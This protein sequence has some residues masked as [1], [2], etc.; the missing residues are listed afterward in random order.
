MHDRRSPRILDRVNEQEI[1]RSGVTVPARVD[2]RGVRGPTARQA[3]GQRWRRT[4]PGLYVPS[5]IDGNA[6]EQRIVEAAAGLPDGTAV[7]GWAALA[8][9][10]TPWF[11]GLAPDGRT[12]LPVPVALDDDRML[13]RRPGVRLSNDWLFDDDV[14]WVDGVPITVPERSV[15]FA[16]RRARSLVHAVQIIDMAAAGDRVDLDE[17]QAYLTRLPS[18]PGI[19]RLRLAVALGDENAWS[20][21]EPPMRMIWTA[22]GHPRPRCNLPLFGPDGQ[23]LLT[24]DLFDPE[25]GVAGEYNG[26]VHVGLDPQRRDLNREEVY[27]ELGIEVVTMMSA[28]RRDTAAFERRLDAA[29]RRAARRRPSGLWTIEQP[30]WWVDTSTVAARRALTAEERTRWLRWQAA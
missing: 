23:H 8:W 27:R 24:P 12:P 7:T 3:R 22:R 26:A 1:T 25:A 13:A 28:D 2:P 14:T 11:N 20:P 9:E 16:A 5:E 30:D 19:R 21:Q 6:V 29:Y 17:L 10:R 15:S 4:A 18:R